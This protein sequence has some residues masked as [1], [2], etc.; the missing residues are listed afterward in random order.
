MYKY[1]H[2]HLKYTQVNY[3]FINTLLS[4]GS[5]MVGVKL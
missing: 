5:F 1:A 4:M 2:M 3:T